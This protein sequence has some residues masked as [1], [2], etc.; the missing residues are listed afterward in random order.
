MTDIPL[1]SATQAFKKVLPAQ[2]RE[3]QM[4]FFCPKIYFGMRLFKEMQ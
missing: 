2:E 1:M 4:G 3:R